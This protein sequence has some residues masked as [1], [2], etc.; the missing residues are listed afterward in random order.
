MDGNAVMYRCVVDLIQR[1]TLKLS[2]KCIANPVQIAPFWLQIHPMIN[3]AAKHSPAGKKPDKTQH[4]SAPW[5]GG[6]E[7]G[8]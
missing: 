8:L 5:R 2:V 4:E 1:K 6:A 3:D 7:S